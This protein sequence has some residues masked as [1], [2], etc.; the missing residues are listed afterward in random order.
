M[1]LLR[2][3]SSVIY[4]LRFALVKMNFLAGQISQK[5]RRSLAMLNRLRINVSRSDIIQNYRY[6]SEPKATSIVG[7]PFSKGQALE[8]TDLGPDF[9]RSQGIA[10]DLMEIGWEV[11]DVGNIIDS[12]LGDQ[13]D[14]DF[15]R[16]KRPRTSGNAAKI[17]AE[18]T[19]RIAKEGKFVL[20]LGGDH[21]IGTGSVSGI[22]RA[23][24][25]AAI[26]WVDAHA[27]VNTD[28]TTGSGNPHGMALSWPLGLSS[29]AVP[30][31]EWTTPLLDPSRL[32]YIGLRDVDAGE[33]LIIRDNNIRAYS[34]NSIDRSSIGD[35]MEDAMKYIGDRPIFLSFDVD[36]FD[37]DLISATGTIVRGGLT[38]REGNY[39]CERLAESGQMVGMDVVEVNPSI[40][41]EE[42]TVEAVQVASSLIRST[43]GGTLI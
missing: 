27:D 14:P 24:P 42:Y 37:P 26:V 19:Y 40:D 13:E 18:S 21:S 6:L 35:V 36:A 32:V 12:S 41:R 23:Y 22:L 3:I 31:Y 16:I 20:N 33:R 43:L 4:A 1:V 10:D 11:E 25:D 30:G 39:I 9:L 28:E 15:G 2:R 17:V 8:G 38:F 5:P 7:I 29:S 34:M